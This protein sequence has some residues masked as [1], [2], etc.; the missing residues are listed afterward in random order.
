M[1]K[2]CSKFLV[3]EP[4]TRRIY[5]HNLHEYLPSYA[6]SAAFYIPFFLHIQTFC[7]HIYY[8]YFVEKKL[9]KNEFYFFV[10]Q[11][12]ILCKKSL[13]TSVKRKCNFQ[14]NR[15]MTLIIKKNIA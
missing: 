14:K 1:A 10:K 6:N 15:L 5:R 11:N 12:N 3:S 2:S 9:C 8:S 7:Q 13:I 4:Q